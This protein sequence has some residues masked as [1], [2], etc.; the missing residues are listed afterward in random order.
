[1]CIYIYKN[2]QCKIIISL[3]KI[4]EKG[5]SSSES[6]ANHQVQEAAFVYI[7]RSLMGKPT[8]LCET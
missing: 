4:E 1:M 5:P 6:M 8:E 2:I 3:V 7:F